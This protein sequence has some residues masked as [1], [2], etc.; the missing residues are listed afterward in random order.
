[1]TI[2]FS[3]DLCPDRLPVEGF[4]L[5]AADGT[6]HKAKAVMT[7]YRRIELSAE[8][9]S[10]PASARYDWGDCPRGNLRGKDGMP[11]VPFRTDSL[12]EN[13]KNVNL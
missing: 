8:N 11:V 2:E 3:A 6:F 4:I 9:I 5:E 10:F 12:I 1:M 13:L 7:A